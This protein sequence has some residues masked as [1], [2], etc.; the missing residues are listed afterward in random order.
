MKNLFQII[1]N[2]STHTSTAEYEK[3]RIRKLSKKEEAKINSMSSKFDST[4]Q[5]R[6]LPRWL[7]FIMRTSTTVF[8]FSIILLVFM[9]ISEAK[10]GLSD[11]FFK[12]LWLVIVS[13]VS[14]VF[15]L[16][17][18]TLGILLKKRKKATNLQSKAEEIFEGIVDES[19]RF[20]SVP[21]DALSLE[22]LMG[23]SN[24][25]KDGEVKESKNKI[26]SNVVLSV[27]IEKDMLC[28]ADLY[29]VI[30][31][32]LTDVK[33]LEETKETYYFKYWHKKTSYKEFNIKAV[34]T[35]S[36]FQASSYYNLLCFQ[37]TDYGILIPSYEV[38]AWQKLIQS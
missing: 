29:S 7:Y 17:S 28:L 30:G 32:P 15:F 10:D 22:I 35:T 38:E 9:L 24:L 26:Y 27:F 31:I 19:K 1:Y 34:K 3:Y 21:Q 6:L 37:D 36:C 4:Q 2:P 12:Y 11:F 8:L 20:L 14:L 16:I 18:T 23:Q 5:K 25:K 13:L 33:L